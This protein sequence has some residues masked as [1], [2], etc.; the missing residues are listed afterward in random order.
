MWSPSAVTF[1]NVNSV[2]SSPFDIFVNT[3]NTIYVANQ[4]NSRV[5]VWT[6]GSTW[7]IQNLS[8]NVSSPYSLFVTTAGEIYIDSASSTGRIDRW[9]SNA[10]SGVPVLYLCSKCYDVFVDAHDII[11]CSMQ[12]RHQIVSKS[13]KTSSNAFATVA[14]S[15]SAGYAANMLNQPWGIFVDTNSDLYV[16]DQYN[17]RIQLFRSGQLNGITVAGN[18]SINLTIPLSYPSGIVLDFDGYLFIVDKYNH[19]IVGSDSSG[20]RCVVGC[21]GSAGSNTD[22]LYYPTSMSFDSYGNMFITDTSN[23]RIQKFIRLNNSRVPSYNQPKFCPDASWYPNAT[24]FAAGGNNIIGWSPFGI[25]IGINNTIYVADRANYRVQIWS[26]GS[27]IPSQSIYGTNMNSYS[28]FVT[29]NGDIFVDNGYYNGRVDKRTTTANTSVPVMYMSSSCYGLFVDLTDVVYCSIYSYHKVVK[30]WMNDNSATVTVVAGTGYASSN[31]YYLYYPMGIFVDANF[32]LYVADQYNHR[33]QL[34][35]PGQLNGI[36]VAGST[37]INLTTPLLYPSGIVL[38][39]DGYLFIVDSYN[40][41]I[42]GSSSNGFRCIAGCHSF[43]V[44]LSTWLYYPISMSFDIYGNMFVTDSSNN[45]IQKFNY[46]TESC[47]TTSTASLY[48]GNENIFFRSL[49]IQLI[50]GNTMSTTVQS[51]LLTTITTQSTVVTTPPV[52]TVASYNRPKLDTHT[53]WSANAI[54]FATSSTVGLSAEGI[55]ISINNTIYVADRANY[56]VQIWSNGSDIPSQSIYGTNMNSYS[57]FVTTNGDIFVDNGYYNG[58]VDKRTTTANTSVPVMYMSSSCYGLFVDLTDVVYCSIYSYH[59]VVKRWMND[60]SATV[61]VVAGTG[62][63]SSNSYYLYYPMGIFVDANFDL[64][65]ADQYNHRIQLF[66]PGQLNGITVAG[67]TSINLTISLAYPTGVVLDADGYLFIVDSHNQRIVGSGSNGF[68]CVAG[69]YRFFGSLSTRLYYPI[70]MSFD[71]YGNIFVTDT[72]Y[73]RIQKFYLLENF[74]NQTLTAGYQTTTTST[75]V[76]SSKVCLPPTITL[77]PDTTTISSPVRFR[78]SQD[79]SI[80]SRIDLNCN[81]SSSVN[82][83]W[84]IKNCTSS[85]SQQISAGPNIITTFTELFVPARTLSYGLYEFNL[86]IAMLNMTNVSASSV[87][88]VQIMPSGITAN[89]VQYGT[90]MFTHGTGQNLQLDSGNYSIDADEAI[91]D[92]SKW[93]YKYYCRIYGSFTFPNLQGS[94]LTVD[95]PRTD[96]SNPSCLSNRNGWTFDNSLNSSFTILANSLRSNRTYQFMVQMENRR[97]ASL[98]ATGYVLVKVDDTRPF[99]ILIG[100]VI[101]TMCEAN[102]EFQLVN[103]TTQVALFSVC[104]GNCSTVQNITWSVYFSSNTMNS[105]SNF[106]QWSLF[107][108][109]TTYDNICFFGRNTS[110][111][112]STNQLFL[113]NPQIELWRFEVV[114]SF[115]TEKSVSSLN[116]VINRPPSNGSCIVDPMNGTTTTLFTV[117]CK[118]FFDTDGIKDYTVYSSAINSTQK[119]IV[120][121][122]NAP[123]IQLYLPTGDNQTSLLYLTVQVRDQ[124]DCVTE[125]NTL[126]VTVLPNLMIIDDLMLHILN[127]SNTDSTNAINQ[128][129]ASKNQNLVVQVI[130]S[131]S[132]Q[133]N[134]ISS[135]NINEAI[136]NGIPAASISV[137]SLDIQNQQQTLSTPSNQSALDEFSARLNSRASARDYLVTFLT[138][139]PITTSN[140]IK[141]QASSLAQFTKSTNEMTRTTLTSVSNRCYQLGLALD[142]MKMNIAFEDVQLTAPNLLQCAANILNAVNAPLQARTTILDSD[143]VVATVFPEDYDTDLEAEWANSR[144][145]AAGDDDSLETIQTKRNL[146][147]QQQLARQINIQ[148]TELISLLTSTLNIHLNIGQD[149]HI[150]TSQVIMTLETKSSQSLANHFTKTIGSGQVQ[151]PNNFASY[152]GTNE[153]ISIRSMMEPLAPFGNSKSTSNTNLSR[154]LSFSILDQDQNEVPIQTNN[155]Q[156]I[157]II[158]PRDPNLIIPPMI[159][160]N[161]TS[162]NSTSPHQLLFHFQYVSLS[163]SSLAVSVHWEVEPA[164]TSLAY[165]FVYRFDQTPQLNTS[166]NH[167]DG[168]ALFCPSNLTNDSVYTYYVDN[169]QTAGHQSIIFGLRE[170]NTTEVTQHCSNISL[171]VPPITDQPFNFTADYALRIFTSGCYYLDANQQWQSDGLIV[172]PLTNHYQT[173]CYSTHLTTFA[174]GFTILPETVDWSYVFAN[175]DFMKNKTIYLTVIVV[176]VIYVLLAIY[177]RYYDKKDIEKLGVTILPD[178][179]KNDNY[180]YQIIV[181]TGQRRDAGTKSNVHFVIH[182]DEN[183]TR[184]R[185]LADPH[186]HILQRG[187][188]DGFLM[189]VPNSLGLL[190]CIRIWHDNSGKSSSSS[191]FLKY[192]IVRDLQTMQKFHFISQRWFAVEKDD[193]KIERVLH[194]ASDLEKSQFSFVLTK[195]T[196]HSVSDG[197][198]WFSI[199]SRPPSTRFTR[200]QRCTCCFV[201]LFV[202]MFLNIMY[203]DLANE[204]KSTDGLNLS[205]GPI[206]IGP[207][208][209]MIGVIVE[210]FALIPSLLL[211]QL[212]RRVRPRGQQ[213]SPLRQALYKIKGNVENNVSEQKQQQKKKE[214]KKKTLM[215]PWWF[216]LLGYGLCL[217]SVTVSILFIIARG[218]EFGDEKTE[219]WLIS[220]I[221]GLFSSILF[222]QPLRIIALAIFFVCFCRSPH[223]DEEAD[224]LLNDHDQIDLQADE[225]YLHA[226]QNKSLFT[227]PASFPV[228]CL[229]E[230]EIVR[231]RNE[232]LRQM[233]M[234]S[235]IHEIMLR[236]CFLSVVYV[237]IYSSR[238]S[239]AFHQ[240]HHLRRYFLNP[241]QADLDYT[242]ISTVDQYWHWLEKSFVD[243]LRAQ[244]WYNGDPPRYLTGFIDD[245]AN[246]LIGWATMRQLRVRSALCQMKNS[247]S[248]ICQ[249]DYS[250]KNEDRESYA[251]GW[252]NRSSQTFHSSVGKAFRYTFGDE[253]DT[254]VYVGDYASYGSGGYVYEF[255]GRLNDVQSNISALHQ[256]GWIDN[257]TRAVI[258]QM[259]LYNANVELFT[260]V[261]FLAE[262]LSSTGVSTSARFEPIT[263]YAFRSIFELVC[264]IIY[265][266][267]ILYFM[268]IEAKSLFD[269]RWKYFVGFWC[270]AQLGIIICSWASV[271]I[272]IWRYRESQRIGQLFDETNGY[273]YVNLQLAIYVN[274]VLTYL[275]GFCCFFG[276]IQ[277][278]KLCRHNSRLCLFIHTLQYSAKELLS[279]SVMFSLVFTSFMCLFYLLFQS[280]LRE[281][282]S[283]LGTAQMLFE[284]TLMKF[285]AQELS[286]AAAFLGPFCFS[287]FIICVVFVCIILQMYG[288]CLGLKSVSEEEIQ[289]ERDAQ[290]HEEYHDPIERFPEKIDQL[291][292]ALNEIYMD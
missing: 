53:M 208:Q 217:I 68:R 64:Y 199:F 268:W 155:S 219:K 291:L 283:L 193:G 144:M 185:T 131:V 40:H 233:Q 4:A 122:S 176:C 134:E 273:V 138:N 120:A 279:F 224:E 239:N 277:L 90:S 154:S 191:W 109:T 6:Q 188:V 82:S 174:G 230:G 200:V 113:S 126:S 21:T 146:Y 59:K 150:Q 147:Y 262:F 16:A 157:E 7:P 236:A 274:D 169:Q 44:S 80:V 205:F 110:N 78:R 5:L 270:Y 124:I 187:G 106:T 184:I 133:L 286:G 160:Q 70:S 190:N 121:Y 81:I 127:S 93:K 210:V 158:I 137:S 31:S 32:D 159:R 284:M 287:L 213:Q 87:V 218:I 222:T 215:F 128:M 168:W 18:T 24:T 253:L 51:N 61:T 36:T 241:T 8:R 15:G 276:T 166:I 264:I 17:H 149:L 60:N 63:A 76:A 246:R 182:G 66:R 129:L 85:C 204:T 3:N 46:F 77:I 153:K 102:L 249:G 225:E 281:C 23:S 96:S 33:I 92:A 136:S 39:F 57:L 251:P 30:R 280:K 248:S 73:Q 289:A 181:F 141:L 231:L 202:S 189:S 98:Q 175:A 101:W 275:L 72:N 65:V 148:M 196:Y 271:V 47:E 97:N 135:E 20:F 88:Y 104:A 201:L 255:R 2:G 240:V 45:R 179:N 211:V 84:T 282:A 103:P 254:Y 226:L 227:R 48:T 272:Y 42:V 170:L 216:V 11:Y 194:V 140:S 278:A 220:I 165:L 292:F 54:T 173:Q 105:S 152:L 118:D 258:I 234:W 91:F 74:C 107:N 198:L 206:R 177:A 34:F 67:S 9:T 117:S 79:F 115:A 228:H 111:F 56:R 143:S 58:R 212:F 161:V 244:Q 151:L 94:L 112:T 242:K 183:D 100:C 108:Q 290:M 243:D 238:D 237:L 250:V 266:L 75:I 114:Y 14:G 186:R 260:G 163:S 25:F 257:Q 99:M 38:D 145:F 263:F 130:S 125:T 69:C 52:Q 62:Y 50:L 178:N 232:R 83:Q 19:R 49:K 27:D 86:T 288:V 116:F 247:I 156:P 269:L 55:F 235:V 1:A 214:K 22:Q 142:S 245:K 37:S 26:N 197:H 256:L 180:F 29:T 41:R 252:F 139:L 164:S 132:Q 195:R 172:G 35:R 167:I 119:T 203:Y 261:T 259:T 10:S 95:D 221:S 171:P 207:Q 229:N 12:S 209:I 71:S 123:T 162:L 265:M 267:V 285:N 192:I 89:L 223:N 13:L 43:F 28:L